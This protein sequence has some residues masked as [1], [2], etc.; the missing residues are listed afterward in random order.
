VFFG[1]YWRWE[2]QVNLRQME[3]FRAVMA[4]GT[5]A[6]AAGLLH[7]SQPSASKALSLAERRADLKL[8]E[9][10]KGRL[11]ATPEAK[12]LYAEVDRLWTGV[13]RIR[14][15]S[16]QL[17]QPTTSLHIGA[18]PSL[19][20]ALIPQTLALLYEKV[21]DLKAQ[22]DL[23]VPPLLTEAALDG[24]VDLALSLYPLDHPSLQQEVIHDCGWVCVMPPGHPL[25][26]KGQVY[27]R[28]LLGYR[29]ISF[30]PVMAYGVTPES[31]FGAIYPKLKFGV[32]VRSGQSA[33]QFSAA[34][35]GISIVDELTVM[36]NAFP[37]LVVRP[38]R[39]RA[40]LKVSVVHS[41]NR[42]LSTTARLFCD[43]MRKRLAS[44]G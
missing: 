34:G 41:I 38:F 6:G 30:P 44:R 16:A 7:I 39:T 27:P 18:S 32:E 22:V 31:I 5:I 14:K 29:L 25:C 15:L 28:D 20:S 23:W 3:V 19:G 35:V 36:G 40:K 26:Q 17:K 42:P 10:I 21:P 24:S 43:L 37:H 9:R 8:F 2:F 1:L 33:C 13:D 12:L 4:T 11:V